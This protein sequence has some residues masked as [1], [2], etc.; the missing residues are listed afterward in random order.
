D[1][2]RHRVRGGGGRLQLGGGRRDRRGRGHPDVGGVRRDLGGGG[3]R[4][5]DRGRHR[6][7]GHPVRAGDAGVGPDQLRGQRLRHGARGVHVGRRGGQDGPARAVPPDDE[8]GAGGRRG[9]G[10]GDERDGGGGRVRGA[11]LR[12]PEPLP[13][14]ARTGTWRASAA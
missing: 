12:V 8:H 4:R 14:V 13:A 11:G 10:D 6:G 2:G 5:V 3:E 1:P 9:R 7:P